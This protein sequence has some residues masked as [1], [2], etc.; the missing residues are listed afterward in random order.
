MARSILKAAEKLK[1]IMAEKAKR[2]RVKYARRKINSIFNCLILKKMHFKKFG[3]L[4]F[5][6]P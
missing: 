4:L 1:Q 3:L 6:Q 5:F 2:P